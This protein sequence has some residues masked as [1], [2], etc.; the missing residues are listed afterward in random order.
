MLGRRAAPWQEEVGS[1]EVPTTRPNDRGVDEEAL[2]RTHDDS[3]SE[4]SRAP[5]AALGRRLRASAKWVAVAFAALAL[6]AAPVSDASAEPKRPVAAKKAKSADK[7]DKT[8]GKT[9]KAKPKKVAK[10]ETKAASA[11][12]D[13]KGAV[14]PAKAQVEKKAPKKAAREATAKK[15]KA[16]TPKSEAPER[17]CLGKSVTVDRG[18]LEAETLAL[19]D[20]KGRVRA[21]ARERISLLARPFGVGRP[22]AE[23]A[24]ERGEGEVAPGIRLLDEGLMVRLEKIAEHWNGR[25]ITL[26]S[27]YRPQSRGSQHQTGR[28]LDLRVDDVRND[29]LAAFCKTLPDT[30]CG[31]YPNSSF[32]HVDVREPGTGSLSW[33]DASG[34][35]E[36][37]RYVSTWPPPKEAATEAGT[38]TGE[39]KAAAVEAPKPERPTGEG[40]KLG[41]RTTEPHGEGAP[42]PA[43]PAAKKAPDG[44]T[45]AGA[46]A[47]GPNDSV[48]RVTPPKP[49][50]AKAPASSETVQVK[51]RGHGAKVTKTAKATPG[52]GAVGPAKVEKRR[53]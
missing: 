12:K 18:G 23:R 31:F 25:P 47:L 48:R 32:V 3:F 21:E 8:S 5:G 2:M 13:D 24:K 16:A 53:R 7:T 6:V 26:V 22:T 40:D 46:D 10:A 4:P 17:P 34:P 9:A 20:C 49:E 39:G 29:E 38:Q 36:A 27:G 19:V 44:L 28:A 50:P 30:G 14:K 37:P 42:L 11:K 15:G 52:Q 1:A 45:T 35:G 43:L 33:I 51:T 41:K